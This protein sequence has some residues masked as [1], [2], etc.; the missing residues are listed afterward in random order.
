[1]CAAMDGLLDAE[2]AA[3]VD[4]ETGAGPT[5]AAPVR[6]VLPAP[7]GIERFFWRIVGVRAS[8][9]VSLLVVGGCVALVLEVVQW[10]LVFRTD[11]LPTGGDMGAHLW[12]PAYLR[13]HLLPDWR[14]VGWTPDW[15]A[16]F[17]AFQF[18]MVVPSLAIVLLGGFVRFAL[19]AGAVT[20]ACAAV[21]WRT[22][23]PARRRRYGVAAV[24]ASACTLLFAVGMPYGIAFKIVA[25]SGLVTLP[26]SAWALGKLSGMPFPAPPI[27]AVATL[28]FLFDRSFNIYGGNI[29]STMA[30]EFA[31]S[32]SLSLAVLGLGLGIRAVDTGRCRA[33]AALVLALSG[34]CHIFPAVWAVVI[35]VLYAGASVVRLVWRAARRAGDDDRHGD[36]VATVFVSLALMMPVAGLLGA[37]WALPFYRKTT[38][39]NDMG[40]EKLTWF[41]SY[42]LTRNQLNPADVL[43]D[44]PPLE[45]VF[46]I[47]AVGLLL[48]VLRGNRLGIV[49]G[50]GCAVI[51]LLFI[52][53]GQERLWNARMLPFY[54]LSLYVLCGLA[55]YESVRLVVEKVW[56][57]WYAVCALGG[58]VVVEILRA[59]VGDTGWE[60][61][62]GRILPGQYATTAGA[63]LVG[64]LATLAAARRGG[65]RLLVGPAFTVV[66]ILET[67]VPDTWS[68]GRPLQQAIAVVLHVAQFAVAYGLFGLVL[69]EVIDLVVDSDEL[70]ARETGVVVR[71]SAAPLAFL[72]VW[73]VF[74]LSLHLLPFGR[75]SDGKYRWGI[76]GF[77]LTTTDR[78]FLDGWA[79]WNFSGLERKQPTLEDGTGGGYPEFRE[80]VLM[81]ERAG[82]QH[83]CGRSMWEY[84]KRLDSYGTPM[85]PMLLPHFTNGC[86]GSM[87]GLYFEASSTTPFHFITQ[88]AL[89]DSPSSAQRSLAY[90]GFDMDLGIEELQL[91]GVRYY[92]AF[93]EK[94]VD[95]ARDHPE[96]TEIDSAGVWHMFLI[97]GSDV[98]E[99]LRYSPVVYDNVGETQDEWLQ[100]GVAFFKD[101]SEYEVLRAA[102]GPDGWPRYRVPEDLKLTPEEIS[103]K[104]AEAQAAGATYEAPELPVAPRV[105]LPEVK[106]SNVS[107]G[108]DT[109]EFDVDQ[110][111]V[112]VLVK[113]S[114]FPN[115]KVDG[116]DGP[117]RVTPNLMVVIPTDTHVQLHYGYTAIDYAS[118]G[119]TALGIV[120]L[121]LLFRLR[122]RWPF[123]AN[124]DAFVDVVEPPEPRR[125]WFVGPPGQL[126]PPGQAAPP[127]PATIW[128]GAPPPS[129]P[130]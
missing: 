40:W 113:V 28:P 122:P 53:R 30:G 58:V 31:F 95:A 3:T 100:P 110:V 96:L 43:R 35:V 66:W 19:L 84:G 5:G 115:W 124:E 111:G 46:G 22:S 54:Y 118:Y 16:G 59:A 97:A 81:V 103:E 33:W 76:P 1:M 125:R 83:G 75:M 14:L 4:T 77:E 74:G 52:H 25:V 8:T 15:Y 116:A 67:L 123:A 108:R 9:W 72:A 98:V 70:T 126:M 107:L 120:A 2:S 80:L 45:V 128:S 17:P 130:P 51:A 109:V 106:V 36:S 57:R 65:A 24:A 85:A 18:Y 64:G 38:Y 73:M 55:L 91:L 117:Y 26:I 112:P 44:S 99:P 7:T 27:L 61:R 87:E 101:P 12:A 127:D 56:A 104:R 39:L 119:L 6:D 93:T 89:S 47:A 82:E 60:G 50:I 34:L 129:P 41:K 63:L 13:D 32:M 92:L 48:C 79:K 114:Y 10:R 121:V 11:T 88:S 29:A 62:L 23:D 86:I 49:L 71:W 68:T 105:E 42:L 102:S 20:V 37:F 21:A 78:S 94:A 69:V 90:P